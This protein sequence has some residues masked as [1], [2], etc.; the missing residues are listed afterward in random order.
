MNILL[1]GAGAVGQVYG[2]HLQKGGAKVTFMVR[3]RY[4]EACRE[5]LNLYPLNRSAKSRWTATRFEDF[6]L[7][8]STEEV[9]AQ[10]WD[11][12]W[13][14][15]SSTALRRGTWFKE[16]ACVLGEETTLVLLQPGLHDQ[17]FALSSWPVERLV[18]GLISF[19]SF[20]APLPGETIEPEGVAYYLPPMSPS[21]FQGP[22]AGQVVG[23]LKKGGCPGKVSSDTRKSMTQGSSVLM[24]HLIALELSNWSFSSLQKSPNLKSAS[25]ASKEA[26]AISMTH[27]NFT[28]S[29]LSALVQPLTMKMLLGV[30]PMVMPFDLENYLKYHFSK[31]GDQTRDFISTIIKLGKGLELPVSNLTTLEAALIAQD[32]A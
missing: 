8:T 20:Q 30:A 23:A 32:N 29:M 18:T 21:L 6:D 27:N 17:Q 5:G 1:V 15:M 9:A 24:P 14:C 25:L 13:L 2:Y 3:E 31:V 11:Q 26:I 7:L 16:L 28:P 4:A 10:A 19:V 22:Q 12:V